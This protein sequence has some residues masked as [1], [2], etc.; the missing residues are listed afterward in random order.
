MLHGVGVK[1]ERV[2]GFECVCGE[3]L[4]YC[5]HM[6]FFKYIPQPICF[7]SNNCIRV[8]KRRIH[9]FIS[10]DSRR[11]CSAYIHIHIST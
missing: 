5:I 7:I 4:V 11:Y 8:V 10:F 6:I 3:G 9:M 1:R 2:E